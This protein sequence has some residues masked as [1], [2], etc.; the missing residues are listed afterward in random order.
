[1]GDSFETNGIII[2]QPGS[3]TVPYSFTF[4]AASSAT[5]NDGS[6]PFGSTIASAMAKAFDP[7]GNDVSGEII[8]GSASVSGGLVVT[9]SLKYPAVSGEDNYSIEFLLTLSTSAILEA[10][11]TRLFAKDITA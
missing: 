4:A 2:L 11:F 8:V 10:D 6:I 9:V 3:A 7:R 1:M 5:A